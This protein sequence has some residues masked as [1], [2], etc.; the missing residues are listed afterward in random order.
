[1]V[2]AECR[3][4]ISSIIRILILVSVFFDK[5][6]ALLL[7]VRDRLAEVLGDMLQWHESSLTLRGRIPTKVLPAS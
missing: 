2:F 1:M 3:F 6:L 4:S 5:M 7:D